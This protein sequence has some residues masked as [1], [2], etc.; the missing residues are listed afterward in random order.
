MLISEAYREQNRQL[1]ESNPMYGASGVRWADTIESL[2]EALK[3]RDVLDY[4]CGKQ[5]LK[6][7]LPYITGYDPAIDGLDDEPSPATL[8]VCTD[9]LEHVEPGCL[10]A[11]LDDLHRVT[12]TT[13]F[14]TVGIG[15]AKKKLPD[16]RNA[17]LI[18]ESH[19]WWLEKFFARF[20]IKTFQDLGAQFL[21]IADS[22]KA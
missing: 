18:Q 10:D 3:T 8:V 12:G 5:M 20:N 2:A 21:V 15:P 9:V 6:K 7:K 14:C 19:Q 22:N 4:G 17:H 13:L 16:G 11:V 1:H